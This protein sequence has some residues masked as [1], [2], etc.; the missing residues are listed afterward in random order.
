M[1]TNNKNDKKI[2]KIQIVILFDDLDRERKRIEN[3]RT[4]TVNW[5]RDKKN[6]FVKLWFKGK[7][8]SIV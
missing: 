4:K 1:N 7:F 8:Y 2:F 6:L 3:K 5:R